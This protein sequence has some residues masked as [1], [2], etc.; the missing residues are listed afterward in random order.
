MAAIFSDEQVA[1]WS[2]VMLHRLESHIKAEANA[3]CQ[4]VDA[5]HAKG[6]YIF[7]QLWAGGRAAPTGET[8]KTHEMVLH[9]PSAIPIAGKEEIPVKELTVPGQSYA[10]LRGLIN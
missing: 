2:K 7:A 4:V 3:A 9:A 8:V 10:R 5:V 1:G 6:S